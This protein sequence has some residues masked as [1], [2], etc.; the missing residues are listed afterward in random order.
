M[1]MSNRI[2]R[3]RFFK[4][5]YQSWKQAG[6]FRALL[7]K[8]EVRY[9][10]LLEGHSHGI[11]QLPKSDEIQFIFDFND[12]FGQG[13]FLLEYISELLKKEGFS[14]HQ[15]NTYK[16]ASEN[17]G[18]ELMERMV[19]H[20]SKWYWVPWITIKDAEILIF[21]LSVGHQ[22]GRLSIKH[23]SQVK[24]PRFQNTLNAVAWLL[25]KHQNSISTNRYVK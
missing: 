1:P 3:S 17:F 24:S 2:I 8:M 25:E 15:S 6:Y 7:K 9:I 19:F 20:R 4:Q 11:V 5:S 16:N 12:V 22:N 14:L 13:D 18:F 21:S 23:Q 10:S